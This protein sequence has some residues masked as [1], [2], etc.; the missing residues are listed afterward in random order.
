MTQPP[1]ILA[2]A[3]VEALL[4]D[5][6]RL[7]VVLM[8]IPIE[9]VMELLAEAV[10]RK[11]RHQVIVR[12]YQRYSLLRRVRETKELAKGVLPWQIDTCL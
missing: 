4:V 10:V 7:N 3:D 5:W 8:G 2:A 11:T 1:K 9:A 6:E 12:I